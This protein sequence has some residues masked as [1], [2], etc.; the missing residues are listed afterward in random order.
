MTETIEANRMLG[1]R[2]FAEQDRMRGGPNRELCA[3]GYSVQINSNPEADL[4]G[5]EGFAQAFYA[6]FPDMKHD[7]EAVIAESDRVVVRF[8]LR[9]T[10]TGL[11]FGKIPPTGKTVA[12]PSHAILHV[13]DGKV[14]RVQGVFDEAGMLRQ[15]GV[16]PG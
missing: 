15:L 14:A 2:F 3:A 4:A 12:V 13:R 16:L 6:G 11:L 9:G 5:H 7:V 8:V 1:R 10:H